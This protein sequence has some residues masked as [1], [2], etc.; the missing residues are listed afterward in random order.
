M[1]KSNPFRRYISELQGRGDDAASYR[2]L[3]G[4][5][6]E[7]IRHMEEPLRLELANRYPNVRRLERNS[8]LSLRLGLGGGAVMALGGFAA[9][10]AVPQLPIGIQISELIVGLG[11]SFGGAGYDLWVRGKIKKHTRETRV[12]VNDLEDRLP[13]RSSYARNRE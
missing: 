9:G 5:Q 6:L 1:R 2:R 12:I 7:Y 13:D 3:Y 4:A 8:T 11:W 10:L